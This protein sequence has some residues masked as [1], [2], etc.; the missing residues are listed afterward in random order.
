MMKKLSLK[1]LNLAADDLLQKEQ[2][3]TI[4]GGYGGLGT[5]VASCCGGRYAVMCS[6][7]DC[8]AIDDSG[9]WANGVFMACY[10]CV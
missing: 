8:E 9:C 2:L 3:K 10:A 6:G 1:K 7:S 4:F 5:C